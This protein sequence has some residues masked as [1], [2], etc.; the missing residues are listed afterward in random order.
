MTPMAMSTGITLTEIAA[1][2]PHTRPTTPTWNGAMMEP[3]VQGWDG[4]PTP[5]PL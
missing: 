4:T 3:L 5:P 2:V 1:F